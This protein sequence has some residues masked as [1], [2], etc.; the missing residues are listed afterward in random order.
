MHSSLFFKIFPP[1]KFMI[2]KHAGLHISDE[3]IYCLEYIE[4]SRGTTIGKYGRTD[5]PGG[6]VEAGEIKDEKAMKVLLTAFDRAHDL[7]YVKVSVPEEKAYLFQMD[8]PSM[9]VRIIAQNIDFKLEESVPLSAPDAIFYFDL[10]PTSVTGGAL[11]ASVSVVPRVYIERYIS[12]LR[13]VGIFPVAFEVLPKS[14]ARAVIPPNAPGAQMIVYLTDH[15]TGVYIVSGGVVCFSS[16]IPWGNKNTA[17][18]TSSDISVLTKEINR[19]YN[20]WGE[21]STAASAIGQIFLVGKGAPAF[22]D[23]IRSAVADLGVS[24]VVSDVWRN[25]FDLAKYVPPISRDDSLDYAAAAG[26]AMFS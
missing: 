16:T 20:Y 7:N 15:K 26:L 21:H 19:T 18:D 1:P 12:L 3:A 13:G 25:V 10:L 23:M 9:D 14:I 11:R 24:V 5:I 4:S 22:E 2:M 6:I 17:P 8:V